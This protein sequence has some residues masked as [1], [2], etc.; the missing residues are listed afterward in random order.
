MT[1][2]GAPIDRILIVGGGTAGWMTAAALGKLIAPLG[3]EITL[4][5]S[6]QIGTVGVGEATLPHI[7]FFNQRLGIDEADFMTKTCA[8]FKLGIEFRDWAR[9]G[10]AYIH[11]FGDYGRDM[12]D[13]AF[14]HYWLKQRQ[15]G[16]TGR[17]DDFSAPIMISELGRFGMPIGDERSVMS[18]FSYAYQFDAGLYAKYLRAFSEAHGVRR[19]E[20]KI[21]SVSQNPQNGFIQSVTTNDGRTI[22]ADLFIDC[23]GFVG[24]LIEKTLKAGYDDWSSVLP[25]NRAV[26]APCE[27]A[28]PSLPYTRATARDAGWQWRIP[29]Q[30]RVGNGYVYCSD[31]ID[32]DAAAATLMANLEGAPRADPKLLRFQTGKR[33]RQWLKNC[34][35][36]G[37][38]SGFL[39]PL[40]S[41]S[42]H[43]IQTSITKLIELFPNQDFDNRDIDEFNR[44]MDLEYER[45][46]DFLVLHYHA[47][48]R[49][50]APFWNYV[51]TM[52]IPESL[53]YKIAL[54]RERGHVVQYKDGL[55]LHPSWIAVYL[56]QGVTPKHYDPRADLLPES[57]LDAALPALRTLIRGVAEGLPDHA[58]FIRRHCPAVAV[59]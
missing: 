20:G 41:T 59:S 33:R 47:T 2:P 8:T 54:F 50:D 10:D 45:I 13:V 43:L 5:E 14:H 40:E 17:I 35:S 31:Y 3:V 29:L 46:R 16:R 21:V 11:P 25:C 12:K 7:R 6:D 56:G 27:N 15:R 22:G 1:G 58:D 53:E 52:K 48:T 19:V 37:L 28:A 36:V 30:H 49:D 42:I 23:S 34:V 39:E 9:K 24:L 44:V 4:I 18:S 55:F 32:D 26:A 51:R 38:A 57:E